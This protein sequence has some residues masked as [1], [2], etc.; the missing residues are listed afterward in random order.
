MRSLASVH[1]PRPTVPHIP[2]ILRLAIVAVAVGIIL[3]T[4]WPQQLF[5]MT[6]R[7]GLG[8][9]LTLIGVLLAIAVI[10]PALLRREAKSW[11]AS[12]RHAD[13]RAKQWQ[14]RAHAQEQ[15]H[16]RFMRELEHELKNPLQAIKTA[17]AQLEEKD[18]VSDSTQT[19]RSQVERLRILS[20]GLRQLANVTPAG[21]YREPVDLDELV[22]EAVDLAC[23][24]TP[25]LS[26]RVNLVP[27]RIPWLPQPVHADRELLSPAIYNVI[28]NALK[29]SPPEREVEVRLREDGTTA[30]I[31]VADAGRG[32]DPE[33]LPHVVEE[34]YRGGRTDGVDGSGLGLALANRVAIAHGGELRLRSRPD[35]GTVATLR[36]PLT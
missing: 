34:L 18:S 36:L 5:F 4:V 30:T 8:P 19:A 20:S 9:V 27:Q 29:Y 13:E 6:I 35:E 11:R 7:T 14:E 1:L 15:A 25:G 3:D 12:A 23:V 28:D 2:Q 33:D 10:G 16:T 32:I 24:A 21:L 17:F 22:Q 26:N 31:E